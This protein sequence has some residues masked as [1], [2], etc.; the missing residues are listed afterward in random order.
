MVEGEKPGEVDEPGA[1]D[2]LT[3]EVTN[4]DVADTVHQF[5]T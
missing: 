4:T 5:S 2:V 1:I 3:S